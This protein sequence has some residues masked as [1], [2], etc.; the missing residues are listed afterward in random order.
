MWIVV[1]VMEYCLKNFGLIV[2][3]KLVSKGKAS[4]KVRQGYIPVNESI[5]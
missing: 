3:F 1:D 4:K 5:T 2:K